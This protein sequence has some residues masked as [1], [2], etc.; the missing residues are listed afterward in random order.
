M[1]FSGQLCQIS[2][3]M[4]L[5]RYLAILPNSHY[6]FAKLQSPH[7]QVPHSQVTISTL[8]FRSLAIFA[9][10][11]SPLHLWNPPMSFK[12]PFRLSYLITESFFPA[13]KNFCPKKPDCPW[14]FWSTACLAQG[15]LHQQVS[16]VK[17]KIINKKMRC[18]DDQVILVFSK[19]YCLNHW[20]HEFHPSLMKTQWC[21]KQD[22]R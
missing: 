1:C 12:L 17:E 7:S 22:V 9:K 8:L 14:L 2:R 10:L 18:K 20:M 3:S 11:P 13:D 16:S 21:V 15:Y 4:V 19:F 6:L 5:F